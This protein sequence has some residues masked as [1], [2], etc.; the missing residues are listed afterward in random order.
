MNEKGW[1]SHD[2]NEIYR[3]VI[4]TVEMLLEKSG[5]RSGEVA[6]IGISNQRETTGAWDRETGETLD[7]AVVWQC[8]RA[9]EIVHELERKGYGEMVH[10]KTGLPLSAF[11][12]AAKMAWLLKQDGEVEKKNRMERARKGEICLGTIDSWLVYKLTKDHAFKTDY[13]N[14]SRTQL[15]HLEDLKWDEELCEVFGIPVCALAEVC[16]SDAIYGYTDMEGTFE[17]PVPIRSVMGDSQAALFGQ[18]CVLPGMIKAT[19]GTGS[20][21]MMN[22]GKKPVIS[23]HGMAAS[24]GWGR[25]GK[26][27]YVLEGNLNYTGAVVTWLKD[28]LKI[29]SSA[30]ETEKLAYQASQEDKTVLVPAFSGLGAPYWDE[31]AMAAIVGM[32]R[33]TG[34][35]EIVKAALD[36]IAYQITD[37]ILSMEQD[38]GITISEIRVDGGPTRNK[39]LM[40][41]QSDVAGKRIH[42]PQEE[43]LSGIGAAQMAGIAAG[44]YREE[45]LAGQMQRREYT[46]T[47]EENVRK[48]RYDDWKSAVEKTLSK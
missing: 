29:I 6:C 23:S 43:E 9:R 27:C 37:L 39:Y 48:M 12:P 31:N 24:L 47:M 11:F 34:K 13:S 21:L 25:S 26:I 42:V 14:A 3:N 45:M 15:F 16:D 2:M 20:S 30:A 35:A 36:S 32:T 22:V 41:R 17:E 8:G 18:G 28:D 1:I 5:I 40:Q 46:P 38:T 7:M 4:R 19:Y 10:S 44:I 33:T